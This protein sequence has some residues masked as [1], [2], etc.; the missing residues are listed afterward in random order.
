ML[1]N[2]VDVAEAHAELLIEVR[3]QGRPRRAHDLIIAATA[4][5]FG[6]TVVTADTIAFRDLPGVGVQA[7]R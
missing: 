1:D 2:G 4:K 3:A 7:H 5:A 6:R